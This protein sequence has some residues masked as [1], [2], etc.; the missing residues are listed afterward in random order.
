MTKNRKRKTK[1]RS[2]RKR[3]GHAQKQQSS[4]LKAAVGFLIAVAIA[5]LLG[6]VWIS[7]STITH[8]TPEVLHASSRFAWTVVGAIL[9]GLL[10][11]FLLGKILSGRSGG[12]LARSMREVDNLT[13]DGFERFCV[14]LL[15]R[16]GFSDIQTTKASGDQGVDIVA[17]R[18][19][20]R[21][22][23]QCKRYEGTVGNK[24]VQEV[25]TGKS[26]YQCD[27]AIVI[28]NSSFT[29]T[30]QELAAATGVILWDRAFLMDV[31]HGG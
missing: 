24:A 17:Q 13:G 1:G 30:A 4:F 15:R 3:A 7:L 8:E 11:I 21:F 23:I 2:T 14:H 26:Y 28:T 20:L 29:S 27:E 10:L 19:G 31:L 25:Y 6:F 5:A 22:A 12:R 16:L 18:D 9:G